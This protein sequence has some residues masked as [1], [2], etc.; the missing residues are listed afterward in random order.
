MLEPDKCGEIYSF[1]DLLGLWETWENTSRLKGHN[2]LNLSGAKNLPGTTGTIHMT[3]QLESLIKQNIAFAVSVNENLIWSD[4]SACH[5]CL[6][7]RAKA[8][9]PPHLDL[10]RPPH[11]HYIINVR[12]SLQYRIGDRKSGLQR[13]IAGPSH[14]TEQARDEM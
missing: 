8:A 2:P 11:D 9:R 5:E 4:D 6:L 14:Q 1:N 10:D 3:E 7:S 12:K 13:Q